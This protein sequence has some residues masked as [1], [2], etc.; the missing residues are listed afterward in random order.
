MCALLNDLEPG[1]IKDFMKVEDVRHR[2]ISLVS[3]GDTPSLLKE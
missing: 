3:R 1:I 2:I